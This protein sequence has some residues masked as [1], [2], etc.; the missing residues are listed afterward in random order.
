MRAV[1]LSLHH[2]SLGDFSPARLPPSPFGL[3]GKRICKVCSS[4]CCADPLPTLLT[5]SDIVTISGLLRLEPER[6]SSIRRYSISGQPMWQIIPNSAGYCPFFMPEG[7]C[8]IYRYRPL[9][10]RLY[11]LDVAYENGKF[12]WVMFIRDSCRLTVSGSFEEA[13]TKAEKTII[14]QFSEDELWLYA[15][16]EDAVPADSKQE[17]TLREVK[18]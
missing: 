6:F 4:K 1:R 12:Y 2:A 7:R 18:G 17:L 11:P 16:D 9:D 3:T 14:P 13:M 15:T 8:G 10:C 5:R